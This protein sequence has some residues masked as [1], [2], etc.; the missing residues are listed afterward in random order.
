MFG[1]DHIRRGD[2]SREIRALEDEAL[3]S[4]TTSRTLHRP[5]RGPGHWSFLWDLAGEAMTTLAHL[6]RELRKLPEPQARARARELI[7]F[8]RRGASRNHFP[9]RRRYGYERDTTP[10]YLVLFH[11]ADPLPLLRDRSPFINGPALVAAQYGVP[12]PLVFGSAAY[13]GRGRRGP[14]PLRAPRRFTCDFP[15]HTC[16][17]RLRP[18][19]ICQECLSRLQE[20]GLLRPRNAPTTFFP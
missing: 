20:A 3:R 11:G 4:A 2:L 7:R 13:R 1:T 17:D 5:S 12:L 16:T 9:Y 18:I 8:I 6:Q 14:D 19:L 15:G 10:W